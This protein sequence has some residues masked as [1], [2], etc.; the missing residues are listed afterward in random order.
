MSVAI[1]L[2]GSELLDGRIQDT[3]TQFLTGEL[4][5]H[6]LKVNRIMICGDE[7]DEIVGSLKALAQQARFI[8]VSG[9]IGPTSDD[10]TREALAKFSNDELQLSEK[11]L[12]EL[13]ELYK[14]RKR[15]FHPSNKRQAF[16]PSRAEVIKN[17]VGIAGGCIVKI[18]QGKSEQ[19]IFSLPGVPLELQAMFRE[20]VLPFIKRHT[21][22]RDEDSHHSF[23][24]FG[25]AEALVGSKLEECN[26]SG[27]VKVSYRATFPEVQVTLKGRELEPVVKAVRRAIGEE[28]IFSEDLDIGLERVVG[29]LLKERGLK[30]S[31]A[32][33]CSGGML[34]Q[35]L[36]KVSGSSKYFLGG[37][38]SYS[39]Q[40]KAEVLNVSTTTLQEKGAVSAEV[41]LAMAKGARKTCRSD[42]ALSIT[43]IAGPEGGSEQKPVGT[44]FIGLADKKNSLAYKGFFSSNRKY[45]RI[46]SCF[47]A[48]E[49]LRRHILD[50]PPLF[51]T[52]LVDEGSC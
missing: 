2:T 30:L 50:L 18:N 45:V 17:S 46:Y 9:G 43:G 35:Y 12:Q 15:A 25:V 22:Q 13:E 5:R 29:D 38:I 33:S 47:A 4:D 28:Y 36:T 34:G 31:V 7:I 16:F 3:N 42:I 39:N 24:I 21:S 41:A 49:C 23:R 14:R 37:V 10:L 51:S 19:I 44:F 11:E 6:G 32:E 52:E 20:S 8:I 27:N 1:L 26:L 40:I 48:M